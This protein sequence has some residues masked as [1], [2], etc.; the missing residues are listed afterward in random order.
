[1]SNET[2]KSGEVISSITKKIALKKSLREARSDKDSNEI[3]LIQLK[4]DSLEDKISFITIVK[5]LN[6]WVKLFRRT[7]CHGQMIL[8][9]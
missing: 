8:L 3:D 2:L 6:S 1:M 9:Y 5:N 7:T 4:I